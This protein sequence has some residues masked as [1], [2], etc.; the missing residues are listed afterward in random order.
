MILGKS[1]PHV[2]I[3]SSSPSELVEIKALFSTPVLVLFSRTDNTEL[4]VVRG[5]YIT[6]QPVAGSPVAPG[7]Y[8]AGSSA[9]RLVSADTD[10]I[11]FVAAAKQYGVDAFFGNAGNTVILVPKS[12]DPTDIVS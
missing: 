10:F 11:A 12:F 4:V 5:N 3:E 2:T 7:F 1:I 8:Y 9:I 6:N